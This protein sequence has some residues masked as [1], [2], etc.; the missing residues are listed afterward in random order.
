MLHEV[1][2]IATATEA[3]TDQLPSRC[4]HSGFSPLTGFLNKEEYE[5]VVNNMRLKV[6]SAQHIS[7]GSRVLSR[8]SAAQ[9]FR[10]HCTEF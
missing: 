1:A 3:T 5:S 4:M 9:H 10:L 2:Q 7:H 8:A 6:S